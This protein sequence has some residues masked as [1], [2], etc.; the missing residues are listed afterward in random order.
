MISPEILSKKD[1]PAGLTTLQPSTF[2][3]N[4]AS[5]N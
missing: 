4:P 3:T 1:L 2:S 5:S